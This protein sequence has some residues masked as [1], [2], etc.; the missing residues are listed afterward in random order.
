MRGLSTTVEL[1]FMP[2]LLSFAFL[3]G[4]LR[5][6]TLLMIPVARPG[7]LEWGGVVAGYGGRAPAG[8]RGRA[9]G[10]GGEAPL[11]LKSF[12]LSEERGS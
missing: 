1:L 2:F 11:K 10:Q 5:A 4:R 3:C 8:S 6:S 12:E 9:P 7:G